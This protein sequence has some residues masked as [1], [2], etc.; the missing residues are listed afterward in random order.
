MGSTGLASVR[1]SWEAPATDPRLALRSRSITAELAL[2]TAIALFF[3]T[4]SSSAMLSVVLTVGCSSPA[5]RATP[6]AVSATS[7]TRPRLVRLVTA[8]GWLVPAF[9]AFDV[10]TEVVHGLPIQIG[11]VLSLLLYAAVYSASLVGARSP[12]SRG[13]N[14]DD[15]R[16]ASGTPLAP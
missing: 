14:S 5:S 11:L 8:V 7:S 13:G 16:R 12:C 2:L 1:M 9:S 3:S 15:R 6:C 4:F 10:K